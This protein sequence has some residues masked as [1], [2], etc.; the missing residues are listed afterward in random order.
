MT[1]VGMH[2]AY[3]LLLHLPRLLTWW[4]IQLL[5]H[6]GAIAHLYLHIPR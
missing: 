5:L 3:W 6:A 2:L 4:A 1:T